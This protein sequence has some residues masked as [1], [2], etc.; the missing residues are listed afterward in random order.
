MSKKK[1]GIILA[2]IVLFT[3]ILAVM[4]FAKFP[5]PNFIA[6][7]TKNYNGIANTIGLGID[8]KG[9]YYAVLTPKAAEG[10]D[11]S[12][13]DDLFQSA[14]DI[15][16]TRL[17]NKGYTEA[18]ITI[19]GIG[20]EQEIRVEIPEI[21][22]PDEVL[23]IIGSS[24][25][26]TFESS[27]GT[28]YLS[29]TD[30][31]SSQAGYD[32]DGNPV[33]LL[34]FTT[35][36]TAKFAEAT[37]VLT[38]EIMYIKLGGE[39]VSS[40]KVNEQ[41]TSSTAEINGIESFEEAESIA[42][43]INAGKLPLEFDV[44]E[45]N[46]ISA[47]LGENALS[48]S[49]IAGVIGLLGIF[50]IMILKYRGMGIAATLALSIYTVVFILLLALIPVIEL[51]LPG[52]AGIIL[53]IGMAVDA[54]VIIFERIREEYASGKVVGSAIK[55]GFKRAFVTIF[56]GNITTVLASIVLWIFCPGSIKGFAITL[57]L[58]IVLS[59]F[60]AIVVSRLLVNLL[61]NLAYVKA[62]NADRLSKNVELKN[63]TNQFVFFG[64]TKT[65]RENYK[66]AQE[67]ADLVEAEEEV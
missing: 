49:L 53:S 18:T 40:P 37:K 61:Y 63:S 24:G 42:A 47:T 33:V 55:A 11:E 44:G 43:V 27:T 22:D 56:D 65:L 9:G 23:K 28:I 30:V 1:S 48:A 34:E 32:K 4:D 15:L 19:Q 54:N 58:G 52:I 41:I 21:D 45:S 7:G 67:N 60:T 14:V 17:D 26:L 13:A 2:L 5:L 29:G 38:G 6:N 3:A 50:L 8:L 64:L 36:G 35:N 20:D 25:E 16:R 66:K 46:R 57:L 39:T 51:T 59:M 31:K 62:D 12:E 10:Y